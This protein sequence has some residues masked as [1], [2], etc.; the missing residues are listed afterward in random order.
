M[1]VCGAG[2]CRPGPRLKRKVSQAGF[3]QRSPMISA[4]LFDLYETLVTESGIQLT[5]ASALATALGLEEK[6]YRT[7]WKMRRPHVVR[8]T[9]SFAD[10]LAEISRS[11]I[12]RVDLATIQSICE[13]RVREKAAACARIDD[14]VASLVT[15]LTRQ[16]TVLAL[17]SNGFEEDVAGWS[18]C[19]LAPRFRCV[20]FSCAERV[21]KPD[22]EIYLRAMHRLGVEPDRAAYIGDGAD[23]ELAGAERVG[24]RAGRAAWFVGDVPEAGRWPELTNR[25]D[26][27][28]FVAA[29]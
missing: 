10:A 2:R 3:V 28:K 25:E 8:G 9:L 21:A 19:S 12:G 20:L 27:L 22:P 13:Q 29:G 17:I 11:L 4:V 18:L 1:D 5:R 7:E 16:G 24:L 15:A 6:V 14:D 26:V 23:D